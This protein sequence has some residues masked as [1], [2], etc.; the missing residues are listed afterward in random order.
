MS[1]ANVEEIVEAIVSAS[2][3]RTIAVII[4]DGAG[5]TEEGK[6]LKDLEEGLDYSEYPFEGPQDDIEYEKDFFLRAFMEA[7]FGKQ[8]EFA[9]GGGGSDE[10]AILQSAGG[11]SLLR[12]P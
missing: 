12:S 7:I 3:A 5:E 9:G 2:P 10:N 11:G 6:K 4:V 8:K 1:R